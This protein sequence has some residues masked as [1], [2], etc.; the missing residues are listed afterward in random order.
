MLFLNLYSR[1]NLLESHSI[2]KLILEYK[3]KFINS[4]IDFIIYLI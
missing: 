3:N 4:F 2:H 1:K